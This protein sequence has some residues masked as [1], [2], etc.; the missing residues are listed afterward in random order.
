MSWCN[1]SGLRFGALIVLKMDG[2]MK[3]SSGA[4]S[5]AWLCQCDCGKEVRIPTN[6][7][8]ETACCGSEDPKKCFEK[9]KIV[10]EKQKMREEKAQAT[11]IRFRCL[12]CGRELISFESEINKRI[13]EG[14]VCSYCNHNMYAS[15][16][17]YQANPPLKEWSHKEPL[18][19]IFGKN[20]KARPK[21]FIRVE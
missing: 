5:F 1:L 12:R 8:K 3:D 6:E 19:V 21:R 17:V 4:D 20:K 7:L 9:V 16:F 10:R 2:D 14:I 13:T 11:V 15:D 18:Q